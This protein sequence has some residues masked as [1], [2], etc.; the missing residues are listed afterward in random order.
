VSADLE[1]LF[2]DLADDGYIVSS[3]ESAAYNCVA[4]AA[5]ESHRWW[6]PGVYWPAPPGDDLGTQV[7][8]FTSVGYEPCNNDGLEA[9]YEKVA[10]DADDR[11][12]CTHAARQRPDGWW[13]SKLGEAVEILHRTPRAVVGDAH[14][15][16]RTL[17]KRAIGPTAAGADPA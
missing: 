15:D 16:V 3:P 12:D 13:T 7:A 14:G 17:M 6:Q 11:G 9:G 8:L 5:G 2:P 10:L 1:Q 4:W